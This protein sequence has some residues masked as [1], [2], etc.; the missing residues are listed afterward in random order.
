VSFETKEV[1]QQVI[2]AAE[3]RSGR[4]SGGRVPQSGLTQ[5]LDRVPSCPVLA[6][7]AK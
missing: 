5:Q 7:T 3:W 4:S 6:G 1:M 2:Q